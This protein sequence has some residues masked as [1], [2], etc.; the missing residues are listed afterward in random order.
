[1]AKAKAKASLPPPLNIF[2]HWHWQ[3]GIGGTFAA[4]T[5]GLQLQLSTERRPRITLGL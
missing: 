1:M 5:D 3:I 2:G 4:D